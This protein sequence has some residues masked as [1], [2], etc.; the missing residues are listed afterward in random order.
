VQNT[1]PK[2]KTDNFYA[3]VAIRLKQKLQYWP[4][5]LAEKAKDIVAIKLLVKV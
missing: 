2:L 3:I 1:R 4:R 5:V